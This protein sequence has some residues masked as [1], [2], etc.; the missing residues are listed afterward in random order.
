MRTLLLAIAF[1]A[2]MA[3]AQSRVNSEDV[4]VDLQKESL[5]MR[6]PSSIEGEIEIRDSFRDL[7]LEHLPV[8]YK[9]LELDALNTP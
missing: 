3:L 8:G 5:S 7:V 1:V 6:D 2:P 9:R 4:K